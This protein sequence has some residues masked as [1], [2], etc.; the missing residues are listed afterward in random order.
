[1]VNNLCI[2]SLKGQEILPYIDDLSRLRMDAFKAYPY[3]YIGDLAYESN[4]LR[5][6]I[7]CPESMMVLV[8]DDDKVVGASTAIPLEFEIVEFQKPFLDRGMAVQDVFYLGESVLLPE[9]RGRN[10]YRRFFEERESAAKKYGCKIAAFAAVEREPNDPRRPKDYVP[11]DDVWKYF[12]YE[13]RPDLVAY[14]HWQ[15]LDEDSASIKPL[16]FWLKNI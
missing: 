1:M 7:Q 9:Y 6:Y 13:E 2:V 10:I 11:L 5:A 4:Y 14:Y 16:R 3:L 8:F 15:E 12:G